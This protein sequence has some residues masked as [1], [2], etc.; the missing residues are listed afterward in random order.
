[1]TDPILPDLDAGDGVEVGGV[2]RLPGLVRRIGVVSWSLLGLLLLL[3]V[4]VWVVIRVQ[5]LIPPMVLAIALIYVL[6]PV[7]NRLHRHGVPRIL[8]SC[9]SYV[10]LSGV[11]VLLGLARDAFGAQ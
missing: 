2:A 10:V 11:L 5:I 4:V 8:G 6:N 9:L 7:V 3:G 1:M